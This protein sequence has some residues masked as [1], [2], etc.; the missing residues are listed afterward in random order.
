MEWDWPKEINRRV[1]DTYCWWME[2]VVRMSL[3]GLLCD[4]V[5]AVPMPA[6]TADGMVDADSIIGNVGGF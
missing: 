2:V 4:T 3:A 1:I 6:A 5:P